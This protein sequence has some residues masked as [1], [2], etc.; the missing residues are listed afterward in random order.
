[1]VVRATDYQ[2]ISGKIYKLG[3]DNILRRCV[4][5]HE[6]HDILWEFHNEVAGGHVGDKAIAHKVLQDE[7]W[8][9]MLI[10]DAKEYDRSCDIFERV[11]KPSHRDELPLYRVRA[12]QAFEK[13]VFDFIGP[14]NTQNKHSRGRYIITVTDYLTI[15]AR[16]EV[17]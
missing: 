6:R 11:G 4:L 5:N 3:L 14:I 16:V 9:A 1:M 7:L 8:W 2:L 15:W 10:K 13:W 17:V 12:I